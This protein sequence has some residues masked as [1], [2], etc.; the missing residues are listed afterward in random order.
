MELIA[1]C[2][3]HICASNGKEVTF[4]DLMKTPYEAEKQKRPPEDLDSDDDLS[5]S[6]VLQQHQWKRK[7]AQME[8]LDG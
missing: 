8:D 4:D 6:E 3:I 2:T 1:T 7:Q 5:N